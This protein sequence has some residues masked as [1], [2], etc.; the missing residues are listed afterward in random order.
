VADPVTLDA[1][2]L[3]RILSDRES[4]ERLA[5]RARESAEPWLATP[6]EYAARLREAVVRAVP[7][8]SA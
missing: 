6:E 4:A 8:L 5:V 2:A 3:A 7:R 1:D